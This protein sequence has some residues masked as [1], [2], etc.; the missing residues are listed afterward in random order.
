MPIIV[1]AI[2][3][4]PPLLLIFFYILFEYVNSFNRFLFNG[5]FPISDGLIPAFAKTMA[6]LG[7][8]LSARVQV[9]LNVSSS[10][11][12]KSSMYGFSFIGTSKAI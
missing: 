3:P 5:I 2:P 1:P 6:S 12:L 8:T 4:F 11:S 9:S 7:G 10:M